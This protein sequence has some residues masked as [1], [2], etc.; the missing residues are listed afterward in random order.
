MKN[1]VRTAQPMPICVNHVAVMAMAMVD[2][3]AA[4]SQQ[5]NYAMNI[6]DD[7]QRALR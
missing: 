7:W 6:T 4:A 2:D 5:G 3:D 1:L